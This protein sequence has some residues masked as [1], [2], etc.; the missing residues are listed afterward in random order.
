M[1]A[2]S[3]E[4]KG[5]LFYIGIGL[6]GFLCVLIVG[7]CLYCYWKGK[8]DDNNGYN[9]IN[10][11]IAGFALCVNIITI[12]FVY[13][14]YQKQNEQIDDNKKDI[15]YNRVLDMIFR[16]TDLNNV[17][18]NRLKQSTIDVL[19]EQYKNSNQIPVYINQLRT[20]VLNYFSMSHTIEQFISRTNLN[21]YDK[22]Y[23]YLFYEENIDIA[24][25]LQLIKYDEQ[26]KKMGNSN[27]IKETLI[28]I[29]NDILLPAQP[30]TSLDRYLHIN[31]E[32]ISMIKYTSQA[33]T[34]LKNPNHKSNSFKFDDE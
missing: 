20:V 31:Q 18:I 7:V 21:P 15:E 11:V 14:T 28:K 9:S 2:D 34:R 23:L 19:D 13:A 8:V 10:A 22:S 16:Q 12:A 32:M 25:K 24:F 5:I 27:S 4:K 3:E 6:I 33:R 1:K 30:V 17:K 26:I 29:Y